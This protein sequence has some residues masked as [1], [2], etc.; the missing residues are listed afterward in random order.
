VTGLLTTCGQ[1]FQ[2]WSADYRL[3]SR[4]RLPTPSIFAVV[5][6]AVLRHLPHRAAVSVAIDDTL[7]RKTGIRIPGVAWR[8]DPLGPPFQTNFVRAQ[9]VLQLSADVPLAGG[10]HRMVP[11]AFLHAPTPVKPR[12]KASDQEKADYRKTARLARLSLLASQQI[13]SLRQSLNAEPGGDRPLHVFVDGGY[14]NRTVLKPLPANTV[15]VGRIRKDAKLYWLPPQPQAPKTRGRPRHYGAPA[16]TPE[17]IRTD[18]SP[19]QTV[20]ICLS[21]ATHQM[22]VKVRSNLLWRTAGLIHTLQLVVIAPLG[23]R[24]R[25]GSKLLY[26]QPAFLIC[27]DPQM[28]LLALLQGYVQRWDIEVNFREEKTLLGVGQA[29]VRNPNSV[30][31]V[32]ALQVA[33]YSMLLLSMIQAAPLSPEADSL[34]PPKW[35]SAQTPPRQSTQQGISQLRG[36]VWGR[37]LGMMNFSDLLVSVPPTASPEKLLTHLPS[38]ILY[39]KN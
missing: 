15:L 21:G 8:R 10:N 28:D 1:E 36:E 35:A 38:A 5:R 7:L 37:A 17:Q 26:R 14:T 24:L 13:D 39:A 2:D 6:R 16:P 11:I 27:T 9:R 12:A 18:E 30:A 33:S 3:F 23:Y 4:H 19:W 22:R 31:D 20:S 34:P 29:Q 25:K 32:P